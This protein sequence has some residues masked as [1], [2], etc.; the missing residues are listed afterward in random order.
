MAIRHGSALLPGAAGSINACQIVFSPFH[1]LIMCD[2]LP[3]A[4]HVLDLQSQPQISLGG[5]HTASG[6]MGHGAGDCRLQ[7]EALKAEP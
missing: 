5:H 7:G 3:E 2:R 6:C 4:H 1:V